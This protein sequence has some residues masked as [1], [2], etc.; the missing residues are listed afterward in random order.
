MAKEVFSR[1]ELKFLINDVTYKAIYDALKPH[2]IPDTYGDG[3]GQYTISN[4][5]YD[6][7]DN[8]FHYEK[9]RSQ[10]FR[11]KLR[12]RT[13]NHNTLNDIAFLE[14]KKK[15]KRFVNKRRTAMTLKD[16]YH[17]LEQTGPSKEHYEASNQQI[18]KEVYFLKNFYKLVPKVLLSY[19]RQAFVG[20]EEKELRITFD[21]NLRKRN[22][23]FRLETG[24][25]GEVFLAPDVFVLE[26]KLS[27]QMPLWLANI[28]SD[29]RC[30]MQS[31]SKYS[32][33]YNDI[34]MWTIDKKLV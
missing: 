12:L 17:F 10:S 2:L 23:N 4:I 26:I 1:H 6:T 15:Y 34:D 21:K 18:L 30:F 13:Y 9:M 24:S 27:T 19:E 5:Y 28:L 33:S 32:T 11:Q 14:I 8:L 16:A 25:H 7:A 31:F 22:E 3:Q 20:I 29:F